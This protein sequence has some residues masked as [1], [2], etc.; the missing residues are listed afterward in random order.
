MFIVI[1][2]HF[3]RPGQ[4]EMARERIDKNGDAMTG[5]PGF[6]YR[7]RIENEAKPTIVSTLTAWN[8]EADYKSFREKRAGRGG[9]DL[10]S[11]PFD[12]IEGESYVVQSVH[13][14]APR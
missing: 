4:T 5:E 8:A 6:F 13:G 3:C 9:Q 12:R 14:N 11:A 2:H 10:Q 1:S 7:Y